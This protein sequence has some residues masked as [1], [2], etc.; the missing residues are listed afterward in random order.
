MTLSVATA[1]ASVEIPKR[2]RERENLPHIVE[3]SLL[4]LSHS[5]S[6]NCESVK[7]K[8]LYHKHTNN[9]QFGHFQLVR[10]DRMGAR[11]IRVMRKR[12][13]RR[14]NYPEGGARSAEGGAYI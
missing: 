2:Q 11:V 3:I 6:N 7:G 10:A 4:W 13:P 8:F 9:T 5:H 14:S 1:V 12:N